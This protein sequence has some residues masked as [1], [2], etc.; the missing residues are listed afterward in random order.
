[1]RVNRPRARLAAVGTVLVSITIILAGSCVATGH[2]PAMGSGNEGDTLAFGHPDSVLFWTEEQRLAGFPNYD[3]IFE[4]RPVRAGADPSPLPARPI[5]LGDLAYEVEGRTYDL[6]D[7][8][9]HNRVTGLIVVQDGTVLIER[10]VE[11]N[12]PSTRWVSYSVAKSIVSLLM[13]AAIRDG[14]I[15]SVDDR[16]TDYVPLLK[17]SA[18]DAV[19]IRDVLRMSSGVAWNEDYTDPESDVSREIEFGAVDRLRF[20]AEKP[21]VAEPGTRFNYS[22][23]EIYLVGAVLRA[24]IGNN[25]STYLQQKI[26]K[27]FGMESDAH[28]MLVEADGPEYAGCCISATLRD[29]ARLGLFV[30]ADGRRVL[31]EGWMEDSTTPSPTNPRY[32][33]LWWLG[34]DGSFSARGIFG[35][36]IH[37]DPSRDLVIATHSAWPSPT[38]EAFSAHRDAFVRAVKARTTTTPVP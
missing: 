3:R 28:W 30:L 6:E 33:Y 17:G 15:R 1:M 8:L 12:S 25:L 24:A 7:F 32:G 27:P 20:L 23:G 14:Y 35:Q 11:P 9:T 4:T 26:W 2:P 38:G 34:D 37:I 5:D 16:L 22:T 29:Y 18:Y 13:G 19:R 31:P 36:M 21:R 10:Y